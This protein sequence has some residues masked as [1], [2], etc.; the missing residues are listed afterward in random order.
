VCLLPSLAE[1]YHCLPTL[2]TN[3]DEYVILWM[4][5]DAI[6]DGLNEENC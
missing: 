6:G 3:Q 1:F 5:L 2:L 4:T